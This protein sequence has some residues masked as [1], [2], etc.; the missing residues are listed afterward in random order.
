MFVQ[1]VRW[2]YP[3]IK[4][5]SQHVTAVLLKQELQEFTDILQTYTSE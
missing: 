4:I 2:S 1:Q 3:W 5:K